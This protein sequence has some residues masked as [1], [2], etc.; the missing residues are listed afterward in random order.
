MTKGIVSRV[1]LVHYAHSASKLLGIQIDAAI[2]PGNSGG[3]AFQ[4]NEVK[5]L[6]VC[7][8]ISAKKKL[9]IPNLENLSNIASMHTDESFTVLTNLTSPPPC[10]FWGVTS[11]PYFQSFLNILDRVTPIENSKI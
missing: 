6:I 3:P 1:E 8:D 9:D 7:N 11:T 2:N 5:L 4:G 10:L